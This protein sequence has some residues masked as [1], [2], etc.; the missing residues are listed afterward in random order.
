MSTHQ[1]TTLDADLSHSDID[2]LQT[3][4][5]DLLKEFNPDECDTNQITNRGKTTIVTNYTIHE[6][7][8]KE[9]KGAKE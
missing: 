7:Q 6:H 5:A 9:A 2:R 1:H 4:K 3:W 8:P